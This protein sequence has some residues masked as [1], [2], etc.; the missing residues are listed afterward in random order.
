MDWTQGVAPPSTTMTTEKTTTVPQFYTDYLQNIANF[1]QQGVTGGGVA[2]LS[3]LQQQAFDVAPST[4]FAGSATTG[5]GSD[6]LRTSGQGTAPSM[7]Q[8]YLNPYT[9]NVVDEMARLQQRNIQ[10]SVLPGLRAATSGVG[11]FG[12][13]RAMQATG[14]IMRD[15][16]ADLLGRQAQALQSGYGQA[17]GAAQTDLGR[18]L[19]AGQAAGQLGTAQQN[20]AQGGLNTLMGLGKAQQ[21]QTQTELDYPMAQAAKYAG[22]LAPYAGAMP[23]GTTTQETGVRPGVTYGPS[24]LA[25]LGGVLTGLGA[26]MYGP[27]GSAAANQQAGVSQQ[28]FIP[29]LA[30]KLLGTIT[31]DNIFG[32]NVNNAPIIEKSQPA[33]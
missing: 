24:P 5:M 10:E 12:S 15:M 4:A 11:G 16:Q 3:P 19:Q 32:S 31:Y 29:S 14:N 26:F 25:T 33:A 27:G 13:Q 18:M 20:I 1:G 8:Q 6:F 30:E 7:V 22:L 21:A 2:G 23:T 28:G 17:L 9:Q